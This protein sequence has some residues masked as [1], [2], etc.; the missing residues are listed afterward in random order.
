MKRLRILAVEPFYGGS[1]RAFLDGLVG[2]STHDWV[3]LTQPA[4]HW[5]WRM[6]AAAFELAPEVDRLEG[7]FD[8]L[9][10]SS[11]LDLACL[12]GLRPELSRLARVVYFHEN[13]LTYPMRHVD[14][15]DFH[16]AMTHLTSIHCADEVWFNSRW[17]RDDFVAALNGFLDR[18]PSE[19]KALWSRLGEG[20]GRVEPL[21]LDLRSIDRHPRERE[22]ELVILWNHRW[23]FD[24][25]PE[26]FYEALCRLEESGAAFRLAVCGKSFSE[27]PEAFGRIRERFSSRLVHFGWIESREAY[28]ELLCRCD[29]VVSTAIHDFFGMSVV[30]AAYA[31]CH[32]LLPGRLSYPELF[33][34]EEHRP[35]FYET[36]EELAEKLIALA[37][38]PDIARRLNLRT[39]LGRYDWEVRAPAFDDALSKSFNAKAQRRK[40][41]LNEFFC[42]FERS[43]RVR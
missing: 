7:D 20:F 25:A 3:L 27:E 24:K 12:L 5:K 16:F 38:Q 11:Y 9:F 21:G 39:W 10:A 1:H 26:L 17:H 13:Q 19:R 34:E 2:R 15:R 33:P 41:I 29:V 18:C 22:G 4:R 43:C 28:E 31:G 40:L 35:F 8:L 14:E 36:A 30:E 37:E 23:E 6:R 32:P 42:H